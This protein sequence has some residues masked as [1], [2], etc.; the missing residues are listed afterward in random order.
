L[1]IDE[2]GVLLDF[3][4]KPNLEKPSWIGVAVFE[5]TVKKYFAPGEDVASNLIPAL[6]KAKEKI[7]TFKT[8]NHWYD[9]GNLEHWRKANEYFKEKFKN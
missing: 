1:K 3:I 2:N 6:L 7:Y 4:E 5:S 8:K 9:V